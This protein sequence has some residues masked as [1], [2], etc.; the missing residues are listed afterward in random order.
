MFIPVAGAEPPEGD[1][2]QQQQ[3]QWQQLDNRNTR[4]MVCCVLCACVCLC[5]C[6]PVCVC[7][8][9][10]VWI[11]YMWL[12][13]DDDL[14]CRHLLLRTSVQYQR[15]PRAMQTPAA[16][17]SLSLR[18]RLRRPTPHHPHCHPRSRQSRFSHLQQSLR[19]DIVEPAS[20]LS[21]NR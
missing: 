16:Q 12:R 2:C 15:T 14:F 10:C 20:L 1:V 21:K 5:L 6:E 9:V 8:C 3:C 19:M 7:V 17:R 4:G 11:V 13:L 18:G